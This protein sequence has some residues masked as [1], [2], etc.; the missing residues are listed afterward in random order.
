MPVII[1][2]RHASI[3][4]EIKNY[5]RQKLESIEY[6]W[7]RA[8]AAH[9]VIEV[10]KK[11]YFLEINLQA[12]HH[13]INCRARARNIQSAVN[14]VVNKLE[15]QLKKS[16]NKSSRRRKEKVRIPYSPED[17]PKDIPRLIK[18]SNFEIERLGEREASLRMRES[19]RHFL[20]YRSI[21]SGRLS[22][23]FRRE[24]GDLGLLEID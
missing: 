9:L 2:A 6:M 12:G 14:Q 15:K 3:T 21:E 24:D 19:S 16:K 11:G 10:E 7:D 17:F 23:I 13:Q 1:T 18:V 20:V 4:D 5:A 22:I 8:A